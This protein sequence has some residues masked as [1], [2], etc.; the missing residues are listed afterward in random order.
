[1]KVY[2]DSLLKNGIILVVTA[3]WRGVVPIHDMMSSSIGPKIKQKKPRKKLTHSPQP[4]QT[5][6]PYG[7]EE[8]ELRDWTEIGS[9]IMVQNC[10]FTF[11][12]S[13]AKGLWKMQFRIDRLCLQFLLWKF[14][15][16]TGRKS[17]TK[18]TKWSQNGRPLPTILCWKLH[19]YFRPLEVH[20]MGGWGMSHWNHPWNHHCPVQVTWNQKSAPI[21]LLGAKLRYRHVCPWRRPDWSLERSINKI[22]SKVT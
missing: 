16:L 5:L 7:K 1:M 6:G 12:L 4:S 15:R 18:T 17:E 11:T 14:Y 2:R 10:S 21:G 19:R 8:P 20:K 13:K 3:S 22:I 9:K